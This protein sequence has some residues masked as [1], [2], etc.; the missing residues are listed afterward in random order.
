[1]RACTTI[2]TECG[3]S[4]L[5]RSQRAGM[6]PPSNEQELS[7]LRQ[8]AATALALAQGEVRSLA[9]RLA[10]VKQQ[11]RDCLACHDSQDGNNHD[12]RP[13]PQ[14]PPTGANA[15]P[16]SAGHR[17]SD[18]GTSTHSPTLAVLHRTVDIGHPSSRSWTG[19]PIITRARTK[20]FRCP[21]STTQA[22]PPSANLCELIYINQ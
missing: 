4:T 3:T 13:R 1:M 2:S 7:A 9:A 22:S 18:Y 14:P 17:S 12:K 15:P 16:P 5:S 11:L 20:H 21:H 19:Q 10:I 8:K 6:P